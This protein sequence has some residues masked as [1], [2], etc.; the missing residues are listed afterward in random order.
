MTQPHTPLSD[1]ELLAYA[2]DALPPEARAALG[3]R[4]AGDPEAR[5]RLDDWAAQDA[6]I[7][8]LYDAPATAPVPERLRGVLRRPA[9]R[10][11]RAPLRVAAMLALVATG[12]A[13]G[14]L[15]HARL[16]PAGGAMAL[17]EAALT[18]HG[19]YVVEVVHPVEVPAT[20]REHLDTWMSKRMGTRM[21]PPDL[22]A[23]GFTLM[24]GRI[25][26]SEDG[27]AGLYM[28]ENADGKRVTLYVSPQRDKADSAFE[29]AGQ[30]AT[31]SLYW[32]DGGLGYAVV[33]DMPRDRLRDL[34]MEAYD[35]LL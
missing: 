28:Y 22:A 23:S 35:Q 1:E 14:W 29:Y 30:G 4:L 11:A 16:A 20:Q 8:A 3:A 32:K 26:P 9:P 31:Q 15:G 19:T 12:A 25:L 6:A 10:R 13:G 7:G 24:G 27:P 5:A 17:A 2:H 33:G 21:R 18:A 34:A